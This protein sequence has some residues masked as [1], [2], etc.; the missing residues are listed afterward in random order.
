MMTTLRLIYPMFAM[1]VLTATVLV[2]LFRSRVHAMRTGV[3][4]PEYFRVYQ[5]G[6]EPLASAPAARHFVNLFEAPVLFYA[7]CLA[8]MVAGL[9]DAITLTF[10][11]LYVAA[12][13]LHAIV[14]L[15]GNRLR[16]RAAAYG[17]SWLMLL[18][19]WLSIVLRVAQMP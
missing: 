14:H 2:I 6:S 19:L 8:A 11:W 5:G 1:V 7:A 16:K 15:R 18:G 9:G 13:A 17:V 10:A 3:A 4:P 12:R